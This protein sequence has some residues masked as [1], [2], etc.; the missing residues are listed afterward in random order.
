M[1]W[2]MQ[3]EYSQYKP[4]RLKGVGDG[5]G[6]A[7]GM[8]VMVGIAAKVAATAWRI[9]WFGSGVSVFGEQA[10]DRNRIRLKI[11]RRG[12]CFFILKL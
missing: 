5:Y 6:V 9:C 7:G 1:G 8:G 2:P 4:A 12:A 10:A 3:K 11:K